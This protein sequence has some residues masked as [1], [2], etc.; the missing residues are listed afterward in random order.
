MT[1]LESV[2]NTSGFKGSGQRIVIDT[3]KLKGRIC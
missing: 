3:V 2:Y 1:N